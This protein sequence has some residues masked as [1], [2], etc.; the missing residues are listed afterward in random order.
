MNR[1]HGPHSYLVSLIYIVKFRVLGIEPSPEREDD[2]APQGV[3]R[4]R[5]DR[6][7]SDEEELQRPRQSRNPAEDRCDDLEDGS[8]GDEE[9]LALP[10]V[11]RKPDPIG[12][13]R[14]RP[15][16]D[17]LADA[18]VTSVCKPAQSAARAAEARQR[19]RQVGRPTE[20]ATPAEIERAR[21]LFAPR[22]VG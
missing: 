16:L 17:P 5:D 18:P 3:L 14:Q 15:R 12:T 9:A 22:G 8:D 7:D 21:A 19:N 13:R 2:E 6:D 4:R 11:R 20:R 10:V 1:G